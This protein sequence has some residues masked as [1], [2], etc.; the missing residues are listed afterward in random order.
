[1]K[2]IVLL[3]ICVL[4]LGTTWAQKRVGHFSFIPRVGLNLSNL[5][6]MDIYTTIDPNGEDKIKSKTRPDFMLG[7]DVEYQVM[8]PLGVSIGA[9]YSRQGCRWADFSQSTIDNDKTKWTTSMQDQTVTLQ[10]IN[11]P[12]SAKLYINDFFAVHAGLQA[13]FNV[14]SKMHYVVSDLIEP[15]EGEKD[16]KSETFDEKFKKMNPVVLSIPLGIS[17]EYEKVIIDA[18]YNIPLSRFSNQKGPD[19]CFGEDYVYKG[20]NKVWTISVGYRF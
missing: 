13:G 8:A 3:T 5:S 20:R 1:M 11:V 6:D 17:L 19:G 18:R 4:C 12:I 15:E 14:G 7:G 16:F 9:Y 10:Y 2:K